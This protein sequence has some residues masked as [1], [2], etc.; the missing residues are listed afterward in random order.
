MR[1]TYS[2]RIS[3]LIV[4]VSIVRLERRREGK[5]DRVHYF[6]I[7]FIETL[8]YSQQIH[9]LNFVTEHKHPT[10]LSLTIH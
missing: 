5:I 10:F 6:Q 7:F 8:H 9:P 1:K 4:V 2:I 3:I